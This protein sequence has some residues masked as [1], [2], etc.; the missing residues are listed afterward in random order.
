MKL[1][2]DDDLAALAV[3][4]NEREEIFYIRV[5]DMAEP[6]AYI[7][8][9]TRNILGMSTRVP[10]SGNTITG[11]EL[12]PGNNKDNQILIINAFPSNI[13]LKLKKIK[14]YRGD[15]LEKLSK[16][17]TDLTNLRYID[18]NTEVIP[19]VNTSNMGPNTTTAPG[20]FTN[21]EQVSS[22]I[23][24]NNTTVPKSVMINN[25]QVEQTQ[26]QV[27]TSNITPNTTS[28]RVPVNYAS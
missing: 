12:N 22:N 25:G 1:I 3:N 11:I 21:N 7:Q 23:T 15:L 14:V 16:K 8:R 9:G 6:V 17:F 27:T 13:R 2:R 4:R 26:P 20:S 5:K 28:N 18:N 10:T 19:Q 24:P